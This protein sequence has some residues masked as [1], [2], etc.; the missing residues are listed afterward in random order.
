VHLP[1]NFHLILA[2]WSAPEIA[3][4]IAEYERLLPPG[5]W[6]N[7]VIGNHDQRRIATR[8]GT[9]Q[10]RV[11]A[12]LLLTLRGTPTLYYGDE[13]GMQDVSIPGQRAR[14]GW[15][16]TEPGVGGR[17]PQRTPMQWD[18]SRHGGFTSGEPWLPLA[19][20]LEQTCVDS[21]TRDPRSMLSLYR[22][23]IA[24]RR[25]SGALVTGAKR[26]LEAPGEVL[27]YER[28]EG[29][30]RLLVALNFGSRPR[31]LRE[32]HGRLLLSTHLDRAG[33]RLSGELRLR[34]DEG[35]VADVAHRQP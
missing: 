19:Q 7:W 28:S 18:A 35:V 21:E 6:P 2:P 25:G 20:D 9:A 13:L 34:A 26:L 27:A 24:L 30:E 31:A 29:R 33:E 16:R 15:T 5:E 17:D 22:Q 10:A 3:R 8:V 32:V 11:A 4:V 1:F 23:L 14:D 12:M